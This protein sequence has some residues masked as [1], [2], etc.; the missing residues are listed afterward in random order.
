G[1]PLP[2]ALALRDPAGLAV[3]DPSGQP[4]PAEFRVLARWNAGRDDA[5]AP[6]QWLLVAFPATVPAHGSAVYTLA[7]DGSA[8]QNP[9]ACSPHRRGR[10]GRGVGGAP[11]AAV[12]GWG[13]RPAALLDEALLPGGRRLA[14]GTGLALRA[15]GR[16]GGHSPLRDVRVESAG[17]LSAVVLVD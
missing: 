4:V 2:R 10:G 8:G 13:G 9:A 1:I 3:V 6:V 7:T 5:T 12:F 14:A 16:E 11:G 15:E 17:P